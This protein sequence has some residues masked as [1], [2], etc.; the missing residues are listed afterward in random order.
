MR[1]GLSSA[2]SVLQDVHFPSFETREPSEH[3]SHFLEPEVAHSK[4]RAGSHG[5]QTADSSTVPAAHALPGP[6]KAPTSTAMTKRAEA[7]VATTALLFAQIFLLVGS[8]A[9]L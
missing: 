7:A 4:Q 2:A 6:T 1:Q 3:L 8:G 9:F 5:T